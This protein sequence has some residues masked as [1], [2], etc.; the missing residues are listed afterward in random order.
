[1]TTRRHDAVTLK[2][3]SSVSVEY[4]DVTG[5]VLRLIIRNDSPIYRLEA[6]F[7]GRGTGKAGRSREGGWD[8]LTGTV[9]IDIPPG[10]QPQMPIVPDGRGP[11]AE[12]EP[13]YYDT[14]G[15]YEVWARLVE[16]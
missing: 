14:I 11:E 12:G 16:V 3:L 1:M 8:P 15:N 10:Q 9:V 5:N 2:G 13:D 7:I 6:G 4:D